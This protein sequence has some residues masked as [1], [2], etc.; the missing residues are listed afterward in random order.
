MKCK[1]C[2]KDAEIELWEHNLS[3]CREDFIKFFHKRVEK[4]IKDYKMFS[5]DDNIL[6]AISG[7]KDSLSLWLALHRNNYKVTGYFL[8]LQIYNHSKKAKEKIEKFAKKFKLKLNI[9][10]ILDKLN[11]SLPEIVKITKKVP[12]SIC[13]SIKRYYINQFAYKNNFDVIVTGH[14]LD[15]EVT[16]LFHN[17]LNWDI[18]YLKRE[19]PVLPASK[20]LKK[21][22][23]PLIYITERETAAYAFFNKIDYIEDECPLLKGSTSAKY[24]HLINIIENKIPGTKIRFYKEFLKKHKMF[25]NFSKEKDIVLN[26][27]LRCGYPTSDTICTIC[28]LKDLISKEKF[29]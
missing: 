4:A 13:G 3:L 23:K 5:K 16:V 17:T 25:E 8:D 11:L 27:C 6:I 29:K 12:C 26:E 14:N 20:K 10:S 19:Y 1:I 7:G 22:C 15:D 9:E 21:K 2:G 18:E 24:K 28:K